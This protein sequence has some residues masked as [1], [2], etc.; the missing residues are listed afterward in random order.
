MK[1]LII[2]IL[3]AYA[4]SINSYFRLNKETDT[5]LLSKCMKVSKTLN[6]PQAFYLKIG[7][8]LVLYGEHTEMQ[9]M[10]HKMDYEIIA[11]GICKKT[12]LKKKAK[13]LITILAHTHISEISE[14]QNVIVLN[15]MSGYVILHSL[16]EESHQNLQK[17]NKNFVK[18][19]PNS[20]L[21]YSGEQTKRNS[22]KNPKIREML[23]N[24]SK[25]KF[26][27]TI[28]KVVIIFIFKKGIFQ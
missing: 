3:I 4:Y 20:V 18:F 1:N 2:F 13:P 21:A 12:F 23:T 19:V 26:F 6:S 16:T 24:L 25:E 22:P 17:M 28:K 5:I 11:T 10:L 8:S 15:A 27:E 14:L 9:E 7:D